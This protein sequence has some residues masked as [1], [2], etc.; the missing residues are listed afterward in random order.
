M[1]HAEE[2]NAVAQTRWVGLEDEPF[3]FMLNVLRLRQGVDMDLLSERTHLNIHDIAPQITEAQRLGLMDK[4][5]TRLCANAKGW[6]FLSD[7]QEI[8]L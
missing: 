6:D 8:F 7:L 2:G 3:E 1:G 4:P 5:L